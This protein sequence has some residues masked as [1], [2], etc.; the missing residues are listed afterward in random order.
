MI[1]AEEKKRVFCKII[2]Q[3]KEVFKT[4][5]INEKYLKKRGNLL[6]DFFQTIK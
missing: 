5:K 6:N 4:I 1:M 3:T 2:C